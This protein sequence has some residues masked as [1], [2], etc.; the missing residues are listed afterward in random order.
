VIES[1]NAPAWLASIGSWLTLRRVR[2]HAIILAVCLWSVCGV[3]FL[4]LGLMDRGGNIK[5]QDFLPLYVSARMIATGRASQIYDPRACALEISNIIEA[6]VRVSLPYLYGPQVA[7]LLVPLTRFPFLTAAAIWA[8]LSMLIYFACIYLLLNATG[9]ASYRETVWWCAIA[10]P[11]LFHL[12]VRGQNSAIALAC[13]TAA[14]LSL[15]QRRNGLAGI[16]L[17]FL[18][19]KPQFLIAIPAVLLLA[20]SWGVLAG[21]ALSAAAQLTLAWIWSGSALMRS[22]LDALRRMSGLGFSSA[23]S[24][25]TGELSL[26]PIQMHSLR[27]FWTLLIP[28]PPVALALYLLTAAVTI[29]IAALVWKSSSPLPIR[30]AALTLA[31]VLADPHLFIYDLVVL[32][33]AFLLLTVQTAGASPRSLALRALIYFASLLPL[34]GPLSRWTHLQFSVPVFV[35]LLWFLWR[36]PPFTPEELHSV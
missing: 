10:F 15:R 11:A 29:A 30:F 21:L 8:A 35:A 32:V 9:L 31:A 36:C 25:A 28:S 5:F 17:G 23:S 6:P 34:F 16:A 4:T 12:F 22:Y 2:S 27:S 14:Y 13:F 7:L 24:L 26:A 18:I 20:G 1:A 3:D 33:P 19:F